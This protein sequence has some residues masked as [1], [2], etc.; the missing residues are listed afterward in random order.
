MDHSRMEKLR[1]TV[2][3]RWIPLVSIKQRPEDWTRKH[4]RAG[5]LVDTVSCI[6]H[7]CLGRSCAAHVRSRSAGNLQQ[8][9]TQRIR[10]A[11][12]WW[13]CRYRGW[14]QRMNNSP[15]PAPTLC[16][17]T[18]IQQHLCVWKK[19]KIKNH[20]SSIHEVPFPLPPEKTSPQLCFLQT[21]RIALPGL[22]WQRGTE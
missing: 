12:A 16:C 4:K 2:S 17:E 22:G 11:V 21:V 10:L 13:G 1:P 9:Q 15:R 19:K 14:P 8:H 20:P 5:T 7:T 18:N 6:T 3:G